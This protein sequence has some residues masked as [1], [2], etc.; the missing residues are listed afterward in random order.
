LLV[1]VIADTHGVLPP[2]LFGHLANCEQILHLGDLGPPWL[3]AELGAVA[4]VLAVGGNMDLPGTPELPETRRLELAGLPVHM[5]HHP[6]EAREMVESPAVYLHGHTHAPRVDRRD[7]VWHLCPGA[8]TYPAQGHES[9][10]LHLDVQPGLLHVTL[11][12]LADGRVRAQNA[13]PWRC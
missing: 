8:V 9:T 13:W 2:E 11:F 3:L 12:D 6:W 4:P 7:L 5:R 1:A 10:M